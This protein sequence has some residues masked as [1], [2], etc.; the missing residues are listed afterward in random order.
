MVV[1]GSFQ[2]VSRGFEWWVDAFGFG[3]VSLFETVCIVINC[4]LNRSGLC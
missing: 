1:I 4:F 3:C 2:V